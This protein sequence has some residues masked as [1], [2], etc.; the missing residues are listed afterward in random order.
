L[1]IKYY[2]PFFRRL[3]ITSA[4]EYLE[5]RFNGNVRMLG[6][7]SFILFQLGRM[8]IVLYLP[9]VAISSV[10]GI[11]VYLIISIMGIICI[12]YTVMGGIE[13]VVW[14]ELV[15]VFV[16]MGGAILCLIIATASVN[17]GLFGVI[18]KGIEAHKFT[19]VHLGWRP[20]SLVLWVC[21]VGFF[22]FDIIPYTS[23]QSIVQRYLTVKDERA[24]AKSLWTNALLI[25][26]TIIIYFGLGTVLYVF[27]HDNPGSIPSEKVGEILPYFVVQELPVG[28]A[29]LVIA[30]IFAASQSALGS[31]MNGVSSAYVTDIYSRFR[32]SESDE[33]SLRT[34]KVVT[35]TVGVFAIASAMLVA[36]LDVKFIFDLFQ[37]ILGIVGGALAGVFILGIFTTRANAQGV[38]LGVLVG[39][40]T[41]LLTKNYT[42]LSV[43]LDG[44]IVVVTTVV[45]GYFMSLFS[46][47]NKNLKGLTYSTLDKE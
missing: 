35:I 17:G 12:A 45:A 19:M 39:V 1:V 5:L 43:Y 25:F 2:I 11:D 33:E 13:A 32:T 3:N 44:A 46:S 8:G 9:A 6:S 27:Y 16:L 30:G 20:D 42:E 31:S 18:T 14:T 38:F 37:Q 22:F 4:Y 28:I 40:I 41:L 21:I 23:D 10:T 36:V 7:V 34:A 29:G 15:Q 26:P 24:A 47:P